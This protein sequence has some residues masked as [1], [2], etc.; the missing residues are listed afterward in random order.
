MANADP[1]LALKQSDWDNLMARVQAFEDSSAEK[2]LKE[3]RAE[4]PS[5]SLAD[6]CSRFSVAPP[7]RVFGAMS[8]SSIRF[9]SSRSAGSVVF[10]VLTTP[11]LRPWPT[12]ASRFSVAPPPCVFGAMSRSRSRFGSSRSASLGVFFELT[13]PLLR[14]WLTTASR[15]SVAPPPCAFGAL[16]RSSSRFGSSRSARLVVFFLRAHDT[17]ASSMAD[18][19]F[20]VFRW[21]RHHAPL[22]LCFARVVDLDRHARRDLSCSSCSRHRCFVLGLQVLRGFFGGSATMRLRR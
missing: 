9:E 1:I 15:F 14:P 10:F 12:T 11:L 19:C 8:R 6:G 2:E 4:A 17:A 18:D 20:A 21:P 5:P 13:T 3:A 7:P 22:V 16:F